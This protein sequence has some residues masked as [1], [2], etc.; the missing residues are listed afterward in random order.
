MSTTRALSNKKGAT[1]ALE[2]FINQSESPV[3]REVDRL[4]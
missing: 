1:L 2:A 3:L 4:H